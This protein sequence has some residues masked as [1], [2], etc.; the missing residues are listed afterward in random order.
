MPFGLELLN[1]DL[2]YITVSTEGSSEVHAVRCIDTT[3]NTVWQYDYGGHAASF[4]NLS[5]AQNGDILISGYYTNGFVEPKIRRV[6]LLI[7]LQATGEI[8]WVRAYVSYDEIKGENRFG[9]SLDAKELPDGSIVLTGDYFFDD[10]EAFVMRVDSEGC[11]I[12]DCDMSE[13]EITSTNEVLLATD[14]KIYPNPVTDILYI[15][16]EI[17]IKSISLTSLTGQK[18]YEHT[19]SR[20]IDM[21]GMS[22]GVYLLTVR[23]DKGRLRHERVVKR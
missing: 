11:L 16:S 12:S 1:R 7:R 10:A 22:R 8:S 23:D 13:L 4:F 17:S 2:A 6:P 15:D 9:A 19:Y 18:I 5:L 20:A 3:G 14:I 21:S